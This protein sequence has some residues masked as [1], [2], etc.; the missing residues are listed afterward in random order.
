MFFLSREVSFGIQITF[1]VSRRTQNL[2][3]S[4]S[5]LFLALKFEEGS[6]YITARSLD[7]KWYILDL[8]CHFPSRLSMIAD[9]D[10][11]LCTI[12]AFEKLSSFSKGV[13]FSSSAENLPTLLLWPP[14]IEVP[15]SVKTL[16]LSHFFTS[17]FHENQINSK[18]KK[19]IQD[20]LTIQKA[21]E[22]AFPLW[23]NG[24]GFVRAKFLSHAH[25][26]TSL[27]HLPSLS[28][29]TL[30]EISLEHQNYSNRRN[31]HVEVKLSPNEILNRYD[32][33]KSN[34]EH[35]LQNLKHHV[36]FN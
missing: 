27:S 31:V 25:N 23:T 7:S 17:D 28:L 32:R 11:C 1:F 13:E 35:S 10:D 12:I 20:F 18:G 4:L 24:R 9:T 19:W 2:I 14:M 22:K 34:V 15:R 26:D 33:I 8:L 16:P 3:H 5:R 21:H 29:S 30:K 36:S 6:A